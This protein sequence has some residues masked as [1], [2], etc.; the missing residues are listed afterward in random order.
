MH[1]TTFGILPHQWGQFNTETT[2]FM[3][4]PD[5]PTSPVV[6]SECIHGKLELTSLTENINVNLQSTSEYVIPYGSV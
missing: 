3:Q 4:L 5:K 2:R 6:L 1:I